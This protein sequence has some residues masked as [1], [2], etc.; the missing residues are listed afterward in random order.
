MSSVARVLCPYMNFAAY[1]AICISAKQV[2]SMMGCLPRVQVVRDTTWIT[3]LTAES[4]ANYHINS[5]PRFGSRGIE[6][7]D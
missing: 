2:I 4:I 1:V 6:G 5:T 7:M 3:E